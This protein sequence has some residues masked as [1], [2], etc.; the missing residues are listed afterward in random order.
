VLA[1][2]TRTYTI[3]IYDYHTR[4]SLTTYIVK[5]ALFE[6]ETQAIIN[7]KIGRNKR[8][9]NRKDLGQ[10]VFRKLSTMRVLFSFF[11]C[12]VILNIS[13]TNEG[14][15]DSKHG[16]PLS[17]SSSFSP[18]FKGP[19]AGVTGIPPVRLPTTSAIFMPL[20]IAMPTAPALGELRV[21]SDV[22]G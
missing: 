13:Q 12:K 11:H 1:Y 2:T 16:L 15:R 7:R 10:Q 8:R 4:L 14:L 20:P 3:I 21:R 19:G 22:Q 17:S 6:T 5:L 18:F 9:S